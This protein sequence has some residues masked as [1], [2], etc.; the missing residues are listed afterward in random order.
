M[1][2]VDDK[3][4]RRYTQQEVKKHVLNFNWVIWGIGFPVSLVV[5][6][7]LYKYDLDNKY[8]WL[9]ALLL[10]PFFFL[11][12]KGMYYF[13]P[14]IKAKWEPKDQ[15]LFISGSRGAKIKIDKISD[16]K[17][18]DLE[19]LSGYYELSVTAAH[20][21]NSIIL[22]EKNYPKESLSFLISK[23]PG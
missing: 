1:I 9:V 11:Y 17:I 18:S 7:L 20:Y 14:L 19:Q 13:S 6:F 16:L 15:Y 21:S 23:I 8:S 10:P 2:L 22:N 4:A 12:I 5:S 3:V